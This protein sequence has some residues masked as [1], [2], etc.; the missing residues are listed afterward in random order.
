LAVGAY[1]SALAVC[2]SS[3]LIGAALCGRRGNWSWLAPA[4]GLAVVVLLPLA[5]AYGRYVDWYSVAP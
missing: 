2:A 5:E 1:I 4:T 3:L